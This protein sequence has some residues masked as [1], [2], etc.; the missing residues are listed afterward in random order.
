MR[1]ILWVSVLL[2]CWSLVI[3]CG[4]FIERWPYIKNIAQPHKEEDMKRLNNDP[5]YIRLKEEY[6]SAAKEETASRDKLEE[7]A[8]L[9][10]SAKKM[11]HEW[12]PRR[13]EDAEEMES[14]KKKH[15][16]A[17]RR[18]DEAREIEQEYKKIML[19][20]YSRI[21]E[22]ERKRVKTKVRDD[23]E[24]QKLVK[25][26][27]YAEEMISRAESKEELQKWEAKLEQLKL[28]EEE[29]VERKWE[30]YQEEKKR[31]DLKNYIPKH[32]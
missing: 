16:K 27:S 32:K 29:L 12:V 28:R 24:H 2:L 10:F 13:P 8:T 4:E 25:E 1:K 14:L 15:L 19:E 31:K 7:V 9:K 21:R 5:E 22:M 30:L 6:S 18:T 20:E 17:K 3:S 11:T 26:I 23:P